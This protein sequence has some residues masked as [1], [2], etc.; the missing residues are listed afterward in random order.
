MAITTHAAVSALFG[1]ADTWADTKRPPRRSS[2]SIVPSGPRRHSYP[3]HEYQSPQSA[4]AFSPRRISKTNHH[5]N[6]YRNDSACEI[7]DDRLRVV[8]LTKGLYRGRD[9]AVLDAVHNVTTINVAE[10]ERCIRRGM[11]DLARRRSSAEE[12][13]GA[14]V[15]VVRVPVTLTVDGVIDT[16]DLESAVA[17]LSQHARPGATV[18]LETAVPIGTSRRLLEP[19][20]RENQAY[21]GFS[22]EV[23]PT[24]LTPPPQTSPPTNKTPSY[25][26]TPTPPPSA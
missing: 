19:L 11:V 17:L 10:P 18:V 8:V 26:T 3:L 12:L 21:C 7:L 20:E 22:Q 24:S 23:H 13:S 2:L 9:N 4:E 5:D 16:S 1:S 15:Y 25:T 6:Y 14:N